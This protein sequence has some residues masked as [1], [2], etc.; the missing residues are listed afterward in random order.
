MTKTATKR[1]LIVDDEEDL[2]D[3]A[4]RKLERSGYEVEVAY[5]GKQ[6]I[7][8]V[9]ADAFDLIVTDVVMPVMDGFTFYKLLKDDTKTSNI[10]VIILTARSNMEGSFRALGVDEFLSKPFDGGKLLDKIESFIREPETVKKHVRV[11][12]TGEKANIMREMEQ[13][14]KDFGCKTAVIDDPFILIKRCYEEQ[15]DIV[16]LD[17]LLDGLRAQE[18]IKALRSFGRLQNLKIITFTQ[19]SPEELSDVKT[20]EQLKEAKNDCMIAGATKYIGRYTMVS[21]MDSLRE[22]LI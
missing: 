3:M 14:L 9:K 6:G 20:I 1:I 4:K 7:D 15:P 19:F 10:P 11:F 2:V 21:F 18:I 16:L 22:Y 13:I 8:K 12:L 17:I 5:N